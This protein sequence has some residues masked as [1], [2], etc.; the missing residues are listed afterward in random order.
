MTAADE[1]G[2]S[3]ALTALRSLLI[4]GEELDTHAVQRR[5]FAL[6]RRRT[7][8]GATSGRLIVVNRGLFG[9]YTPQDVR[10]QDLQDAQLRVGVFGASLSVSVHGNADLASAEGPRRVV[11][12]DGLR[13]EEAQEVY[14]TCQAQEQAWR[15]KRRVRELEELR[16]KSGGI[17]LAGGMGAAPGA[18][19]GDEGSQALASRL[20]RAKDMLQQGLLTDAEF[21][22]V[23]ARILSEL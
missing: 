15:E 3:R 17:N 19:A 20:Q 5:L 23:K 18:G 6:T 14:R 2:V 1:P 13:K 7:I 12:V 9:D 16:A 11:Q 10:W 4:P 8:V 22:Q 21:E